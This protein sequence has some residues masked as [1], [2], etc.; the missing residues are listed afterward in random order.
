[1]T[2]EKKDDGG[3]IA[4]AKRML[5]KSEGLSDFMRGALYGTMTAFDLLNAD[6]RQVINK[7]GEE[8]KKVPV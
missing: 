5:Q 3:K 7:E 1:M 6:R 8:V 2:Q 4:Q